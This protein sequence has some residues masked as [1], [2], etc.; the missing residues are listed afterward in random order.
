VTVAIRGQDG[1]L[2][3]VN[4]PADKFAARDW[5]RRDGDGRDVTEAAGMPGLSCDGVGCVV[6][7]TVRI[8]ISRY[9]EALEEDC[10]RAKVVVSAAASPD[11]NGP[12]VVIDQ[13]AAQAGEGWRVTLSPTPIAI[14]VR[15]LRGER[16]WVAGSR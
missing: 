4:K 12:A 7:M 14:S 6:T 15:D 3:F 8:A 10:G 2:H 13:N 11:C 5:L 16:P 1:R 9:P